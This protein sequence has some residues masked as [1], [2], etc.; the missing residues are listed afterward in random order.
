MCST[1]LVFREEMIRKISDSM[2]TRAALLY[3][4]AYTYVEGRF[5]ITN[6]QVVHFA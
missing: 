6:F 4:N 5:K 3:D 1:I 2:R